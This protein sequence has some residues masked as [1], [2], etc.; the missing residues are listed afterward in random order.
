M[1]KLFI[2]RFIILCFVFLVYVIYMWVMV[3]KKIV[4]V[5][6]WDWVSFVNN[7]MNSMRVK[8]IVIFLK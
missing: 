7:M 8:L 2:V 3:R 1:Y 6:L 5:L 4:N